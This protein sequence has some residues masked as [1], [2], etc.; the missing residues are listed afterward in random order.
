[1]LVKVSLAAFV[2][3]LTRSLPLPYFHSAGLS[4]RSQEKKKKREREKERLNG[5][6]RA[7]IYTKV[8]ETLLKL[9]SCQ[10]PDVT[11]FSTASLL[12]FVSQKTLKFSVKIQST[13]YMKWRCVE[14]SGLTRLNIIREN[15]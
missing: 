9:K 8:E 7:G 14:L 15:A 11:F 4:Q 10:K 2:C 13:E 1:M 5:F 3:N 12:Y 6:L